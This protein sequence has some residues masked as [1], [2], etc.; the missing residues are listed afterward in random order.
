MVSGVNASYDMLETCVS[1]NNY[2]SPGYSRYFSVDV[3]CVATGYDHNARAIG[4]IA[5]VDE[6]ERILLDLYVKPSLPVVSY[7]TPLT[8]IVKE[9]LD[10]YG[11]SLEFALDMLRRYLPKD[12]ILVG[13]NIGKD[14]A[15]LQ[16]KEGIDFQSMIDLAGLYKVWNSKY[17]SW[18]VYS[19]EHLSNVVFGLHQNGQAHNAVDD[20]IKSIKLYKYHRLH[21]S[22]RASWEILCRDLL[23]IPA[24]LSFSKRHPRFQGVCMGNRKL[25]KC[26]APFLGW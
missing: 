24:P 3:E 22:N 19:L 4:Q 12:G 9:T 16:L 8:G 10:T 11:V 21:S 17:Q 13:Q 14:V 20:A 15:W 23:R 1:F 26:G 7:L 18:T 25:C 2:D 6:Y 5:L